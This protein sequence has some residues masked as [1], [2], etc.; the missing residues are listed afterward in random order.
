MKA[1]NKKYLSGLLAV[2]GG[3]L[4]GCATTNVDNA[5][6]AA[7]QYEGDAEATIGQHS[8]VSSSSVQVEMSDEFH[9]VGKKFRKEDHQVLP[10]FFRETY[11]F[12]RIDPVT[13]SELVSYIN[14]ET[15]VRVDLTDDAIAYIE[16]LASK[17]EESED[18]DVELAE[19]EENID[20]SVNVSS[21]LSEEGSGLSGSDLL[22]TVEFSGTLED[23]LNHILGR[24]NLSWEWKNNRIEVFHMTEKT[25]IID[26]DLADISFEAAIS[27][28]SG[29]S[30][31]FG[32]TNNMGSM[33][34]D[35]ETVIGGLLSSTGK[36]SISRQLSTVTVTDTPSKLEKISR[37]INSINETASK[38]IM[39]RVQVLDIE[40]NE[41]GDYGIDWEG[42]FSNSSRIG[43]SLST[44]FL[45][46]TGSIFELQS[47]EGGFAGSQAMVSAL[48][49][50]RNVSTSINTNIHTTN[51]RPVPLQ[52]GNQ[53]DYIKTMSSV[54]DEGVI[55]TDVEIES[56]PTG[57]MLN[58]LPRVT[59]TG[60]IAMTMGMDISDGVVEPKV[61]PDGTELGLPDLNSRSFIQR[62]ISSNGQPLLLA[63]FER[64]TAESD[65]A[66]LGSNLS[67]L[68]GGR[69]GANKS[70]VM[71]VIVITP[72]IMK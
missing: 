58:I 25:F 56:M 66:K 40:S 46:S 51:G 28:G 18:A 62:A 35:L 7:K 64:N 20:M 1:I 26:S 29:S 60:E 37:Y 13:F 5:S 9:I 15:N 2:S 4:S 44:P 54:N 16:S 30:Q 43:A 41:G 59:S 65:Q 23:F 47:L 3:V 22:F 53:K 24:V 63:G 67:W 12:N 6:E 70:K 17:G 48:S 71:T 14:K 49:Q 34:G 61:L 39:M 10:S 55:T 68:A 52:I 27:G 45:S 11:S 33:F 36:L 69:K 57:F 31:S 21:I 50:N 42:V 38:Q 72:Y 19:D 8:K 32:M